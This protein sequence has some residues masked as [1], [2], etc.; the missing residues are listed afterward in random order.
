MVGYIALFCFVIGGTAGALEGK[1]KVKSND[2]KAGEVK[3]SDLASDSIGSSKVIDGSIGGAD[4]DESSLSLPVAPTTLPPSGAA[5]GDLSG[6]YPNP[7]VNEAGVDLGGDLSGTVANAQLDADTVDDAQIVNGETTIVFSASDAGGAARSSASPPDA[8]QV[9]GAPAL[10]FDATAPEEIEFWMRAPTDSSNGGVKL[11]YSWSSATTGGA[12][13]WDF[14]VSAISDGETLSAGA[15][16]DGSQFPQNPTANVLHTITATLVSGP[17]VFST[18]D[19]LKV[20]FARDAGNASDTLAGDAAFH[21][22]QLT[23]DTPR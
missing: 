2:I 17:N 15:F 9:L 23:F 4:V 3:K 13:K 19:L 14:T 6:S 22:V 18:G 20:E 11:S 8:G 12:V 5:G 1:N 10:F 16:I 21:Q 7:G